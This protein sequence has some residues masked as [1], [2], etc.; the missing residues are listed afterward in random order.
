MAVDMKPAPETST[1]EL[2]GGI[3]SDAQDLLKQQFALFRHEVI[4]D[5][6]KTRDAGV[7]LGLGAALALVG[8]IL[9]MM[10]LVHAIPWFFPNFPL[11]GSF[12]LWSAGMFVV[13]VVLYQVGSRKLDKVNILPEQTAE[14]IKENVQWITHPK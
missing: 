1:T 3:L 5:L 8:S 9:F 13:A 2:V 4:D 14:A 11:W 10:M 6:R 12:G 7:F